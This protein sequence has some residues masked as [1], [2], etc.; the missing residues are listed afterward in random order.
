MGQFEHDLTGGSVSRQLIRFSL[1]FLL[2]NLLQAFYN[3]A[4]MLIISWYG[5]PNGV[6]GVA[7]GG[8]ITLILTNF[9]V[10]LTVGGTVLIGQ[11]FGA[12]R[13]ED[14]KKTISTMLSVLFLISIA[15]TVIMLLL[16]GPILRR[17]RVPEE[18]FEQAQRYL[19]ICMLGTVFI[20]G[21]NAI[22][23]ILRGMGDSKRP[24]Y[25]V[26][27][28]CVANIG[29]DFLFVGALHM[30]AAGVAIATVIAQALSLALSVRYLAKREFLFDFKWKSFRIDREK[31]RLLMKVGIPTSLQN[32]I[33]GISFLVMTSLVNGFGV[34]ASAALGIVATFN[35][36]A[37][38][39]AIAMSASV[40]SMSAQNI[41]AHLPE[42]AKKTMYVG[43]MAVF[44]V[45]AAFFLMAFF[46]PA[47][48]MG[49]FTADP[50]VIEQGVQYI[51]Y[52]CFD[53]LIVPFAFC[54]NG[55]LIGAG[56]TTFTMINSM[57]SSI[58]L[59]I[60]LALLLGMTLHMGLVGIGLAAPFAST[61]AVLVSAL[62]IKSG[63]WSK[64][65]LTGKTDMAA[66][67][68]GA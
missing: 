51:R 18:A 61:G 38:L 30:D 63:R 54:V 32:I 45:C 47:T 53:Y 6:A 19:N 33:V 42:R 14:M 50:S 49:I 4:G 52:F 2:S 48:V 59:R 25:F 44:P 3:V 9:V 65:R 24:L 58:L 39:P 40:A 66:E 46:A 41:G 28:A 36:F 15:L 67:E 16:S 60:P 10:G 27:I 26:A 1:P 23:A 17:I 29:L 20:F 64:S 31:L 11:Y 12:R 34:F 56:H 68:A 13:Y 62:Y 37:I 43:I 55:L 8:Q 22:S 57:I 7:N 35:N 21:Y 5:G